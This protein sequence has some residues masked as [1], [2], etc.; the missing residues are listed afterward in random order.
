MT[1]LTAARYGRLALVAVWQNDRDQSQKH[2]KVSE[3]LK[4]GE[5]SEEFKLLLQTQLG[6]ANSTVTYI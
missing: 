2:S 5:S 4:E 1:K 6:L 3:E